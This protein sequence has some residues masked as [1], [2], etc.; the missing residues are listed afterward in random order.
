MHQ[1]LKSCVI[2]RSWSETETNEAIYTISAKDCFAPPEA[3]GAMKA[4]TFLMQPPFLSVQ[5]SPH[6]VR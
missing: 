5:K 4:L 1:K 2:A 3:S 6:F